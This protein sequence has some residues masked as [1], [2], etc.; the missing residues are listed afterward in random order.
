MS[1][2]QTRLRLA[3][4]R[5]MESGQSWNSDILTESNM[6]PWQAEALK[7]WLRVVHCRGEQIG[8][9]HSGEDEAADAVLPDCGAPAQS[10]RPGAQI[11]INLK[12]LVDT[13]VLP[14]ALTS[15]SLPRR[16]GVRES[17]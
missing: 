10:R 11:G 2:L 12:P 4:S 5:F 7:R 3:A 15:S 1:K 6:A 13:G 17:V 9:R 8:R 14:S 16:T